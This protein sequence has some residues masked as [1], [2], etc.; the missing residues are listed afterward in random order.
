MAWSLVVGHEVQSTGAL[1]ARALRS[2]IGQHTRF[3]PRAQVLRMGVRAL[4]EA[5]LRGGVGPGEVLQS[6]VEH[7]GRRGDPKALCQPFR[8]PRMRRES[9]L[10]IRKRGSEQP[11]GRQS[12]DLGTLDDFRTPFGRSRQGRQPA[13]CAVGIGCDR[14]RCRSALLDIGDTRWRRNHRRK[15]QRCQRGQEYGQRDPAHHQRRQ[16]PDSTAPERYGKRARC[17][18]EK[19]I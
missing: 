2:D 11:L 7:E 6:A 1:R 17:D 12:P 4:D 13:L 3:E 8:C 10:L 14:V 18:P 9:I 15:D 16:R 19:R 5:A